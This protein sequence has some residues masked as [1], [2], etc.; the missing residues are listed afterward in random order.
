MRVHGLLPL[1]LLALSFVA[2]S[3]DS[4][5]P[6][7]PTIEPYSGSE[8]SLGFDIR[9]LSQ[10]GRPFLASYTSRGK[11]ARFR[12]ELDPATPSKNTDLPMSFGKGRF[13]AES[14][15]EPEL[16]LADLAKVL[17]AKKVPKRA[18]R[19]AT[20]PFEYVILGEKQSRSKDGSF[21]DSPSGD[22]TLMK[23]FF[24]DDQGEVYL[25]FSPAHNKAEFSI[26]DEDYGDFV[27]S[28]LAKVL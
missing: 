19:S 28:E 14:G 23:L 16:F 26:K 27:I 20:L 8:S 6:S 25:N 24:G 18:S 11:T 17:E 3:R 15:S 7:S 12:I 22:W 2:C 10:P 1:V 9:P 13:L 4:K 21:S 5:P